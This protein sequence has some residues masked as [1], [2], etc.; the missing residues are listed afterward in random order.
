MFGFSSIQALRVTLGICHFHCVD[1]GTCVTHNTHTCTT[2]TS[3]KI[4][5][6]AHITIPCP[7]NNAYNLLIKLICILA[8]VE[9]SS[10]Y[11]IAFFV[12]FISNNTHTRIVSLIWLHMLHS[13]YNPINLL[14]GIN[15]FQTNPYKQ[16]ITQIHYETED[17]LPLMP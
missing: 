5:T 12:Y 11:F 8:E 14:A 15:S 3:T 4:N 17:S 2:R 13:Q 1:R 9:S 10:I 6:N 7:L 16:R